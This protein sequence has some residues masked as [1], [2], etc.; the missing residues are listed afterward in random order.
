VSE[1]P[2]VDL[3]ALRPT[4]DYAARLQAGE[5]AFQNCERCGESVFFP[6]VLCPGCGSTRLSWRQS[7]GA[8]TVYSATTVHRRDHDPYTVGLIDL[9]EGIRVMTW[10]DDAQPDVPPIGWRAVVSVAEVNGQPALRASLQAAEV[11]RA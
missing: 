6:R 3:G 4:A 9:D 8:G 1:N 11:N 10:I 5:I 2:P 7:A